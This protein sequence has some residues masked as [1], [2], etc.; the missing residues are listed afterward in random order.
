MVKEVN[1]GW[2]LDPDEVSSE[3][4][5]GQPVNKNSQKNAKN[6][7]LEKL[8]FLDN[9]VGVFWILVQVS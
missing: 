3:G 8:G 7:N 6:Q 4:L 1:F 5:E 9:P 2:L